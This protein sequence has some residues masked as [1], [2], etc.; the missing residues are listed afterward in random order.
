[1]NL[2]RR[3]RSSAAGAEVVLQTARQAKRG[4][5]RSTSDS[6]PPPQGPPGAGGWALPP[7]QPPTYPYGGQTSSM[8]PLPAPASQSLGFSIGAIVMGCIATLFFPI[9]FGPMGI[10]LAIAALVR[11]ERWGIAGMCVAA[12]GTVFGMILGILVASS[13]VL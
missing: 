9:L 10:G 13:G 7:Q 1:V 12:G 3:G 6:L 5:P 4:L 11:K 2:R 8:G